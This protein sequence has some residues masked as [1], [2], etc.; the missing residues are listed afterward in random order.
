MKTLLCTLIL[1]TL[2]T[3]VAKADDITISF[4]QPNQTVV[5]GET[6]E[7]FGSITNDTA[8]TIYLNSDDLN[9]EGLSFTT[10]DQ[11]LSNVPISLSPGGQPGDSSSDIELFDVTASDPLLDAVGVYSGTYT[12]FGGAD[13]NAQDNLGSTA[14][15][16]TTEAPVPEPPSIYL[17]LGGILVTLIPISRSVRPEAS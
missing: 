17:L 11:F 7:F 15:S 13:G 12:L 8:S 5:A 14:F 3:A 10:T 2:G 6:I 9:L 16:V 4:D 1:A